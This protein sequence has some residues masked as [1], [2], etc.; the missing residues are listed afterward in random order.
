MMQYKTIYKNSDLSP[1]TCIT[2]SNPPSQN[3]IHF[4]STNSISR[5]PLHPVKIETERLKNH[6]RNPAPWK[7]RSA[8]K[9]ARR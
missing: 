7:I 9:R 2:T 4:I 8:R 3:E 6:E 1:S 5:H